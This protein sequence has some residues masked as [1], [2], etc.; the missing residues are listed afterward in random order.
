MAVLDADPGR[1][2]SGASEVPADNDATGLVPDRP[3][4][5]PGPAVASA[6]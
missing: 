2:R 5:R 3:R 1:E 6:R 4:T